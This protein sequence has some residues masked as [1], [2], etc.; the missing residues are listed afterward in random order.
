M[1]LVCECKNVEITIA[2]PN[3]PCKQSKERWLGNISW[4]KPCYVKNV[5]CS[6]YTKR[7]LHK[8]KNTVNNTTNI[9]YNMHPLTSVYIT[10][11][12]SCERSVPVFLNKIADNWVLVI[13][14]TTTDRK[15]YKDCN[16]DWMFYSI[17]LIDFS[18][19]G[20]GFSSFL[21]FRLQLH[22]FTWNMHTVIDKHFNRQIVF[23]IR[24]SI[25]FTTQSRFYKKND[26]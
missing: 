10:Y 21:A 12:G 11:C 22:A 26:D 6:L 16:R 9:N 1:S 2:I 3:P 17:Y 14:W 13:M 23:L 5:F 7:L 19:F 4:L 25:C 18:I 20:F 8:R 24:F 15:W